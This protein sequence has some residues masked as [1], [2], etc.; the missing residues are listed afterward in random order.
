[1]YPFF[2]TD[3]TAF[4]FS[5]KIKKGQIFNGCIIFRLKTKE[6]YRCKRDGKYGLNTLNILK[7][8][9]FSMYHQV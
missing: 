8:I 1:M 9:G 3:K 7:P 2:V 6:V 5:N 4:L